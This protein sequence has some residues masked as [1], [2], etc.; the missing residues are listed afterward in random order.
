[1]AKIENGVE[2]QPTEAVDN[3]VSLDTTQPS[4]IVEIDKSVLENLLIEVQN[5]KNQVNSTT[6]QNKLRA[7]E[8]SKKELDKFAFSVKLFPMADYD[9]PVISWRTISNFVDTSKEEIQ[10]QQIIEITFITQD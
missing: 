10:A 6:D 1:M 8:D 7:F 3:Q 2:K 4:Q 9:C 5:L